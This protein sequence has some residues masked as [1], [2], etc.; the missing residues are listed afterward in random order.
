MKL[1]AG[2]DVSASIRS[3]VEWVS[4]KSYF[5]RLS[6]YQDRLVEFFHLILISSLR[7]V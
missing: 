2:E 3:Q 5:L 6:K 7:P 4:E 1:E